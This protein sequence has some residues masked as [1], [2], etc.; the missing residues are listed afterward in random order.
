MKYRV[1]VL[2]ST[3]FEVA[4]GSVEEAYEAYAEGDV[5][6]IDETTL[7]IEVST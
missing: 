1:T 5:L 3:V 4:A 7:D 6:Q 2:R